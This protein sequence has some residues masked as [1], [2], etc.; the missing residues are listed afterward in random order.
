[1]AAKKGARDEREVLVLRRNYP[2]A[3][4]AVWRAWIDAAAMRIWFGQSDASCWEAD[5]DVRPGG[6]LRLVMQDTEG[7]RYEAHGVYREVVPDRR[8]VFGWTWKSGEVATEAVITVDLKA[9][10]GG[11][12][13]E[14]KLDPV[15][16][17]RERDAW[18]ADFNRLGVLLQTE[19]TT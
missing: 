19:R 9:V 12:E 13:L 7:N 4:Q 1:M 5:M 17:P 3:P 15:I 8:L 14:F 16:D 6:R 18:R 10:A 11:T 2:V